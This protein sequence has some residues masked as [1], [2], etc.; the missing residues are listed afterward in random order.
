M[1]LKKIVLRRTYIVDEYIDELNPYD[2]CKHWVKDEKREYVSGTMKEIVRVMIDTFLDVFS[3][4]YNK[5]FDKVYG[6][7]VELGYPKKIR[8]FFID[9]MNKCNEFLLESEEKETSLQKKL[10]KLIKQNGVVIA[11]KAVGGFNNLVKILKLDL[12]DIN[13]QEML[14]KNYIY[15][16]NIEDIEVNFI[17]VKNRANRKLIKIYFETDSNARNIDSWY[18]M[19]IKDEMNDFFPFGIDLSW[20]PVN[21]PQAKIMIDTIIGGVVDFPE[22]INESEGKKLPLFFTRRVDHHKFEK[23]MRKGIPYIF[24]D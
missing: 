16:A 24:H 12:G 20:F 7:L 21:Y 23:M 15:F 18:A 4:D 1:N 11:S 13:T 14:V 6:I 2:V 19:T 22:E 5:V 17:E 3:E 8:D 10:S 9:S